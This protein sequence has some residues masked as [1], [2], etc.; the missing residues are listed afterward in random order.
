MLE[1]D[2]K[3]NLSTCRQVR[4]KYQK[5][6]I[7][8]NTYTQI[9][10]QCVF[11]VQ[12]RDSIISKQW[13]AELHKYITG[14]IQNYGHKVLAIN[15]MPD[16]VHVFFGM[17]PTQSLSDLMQDV[18][19]DSSKWINKNRFIKGHFSWQ[20]GYGGFSYSKSQVNDVISYINNQ[21]KHHKKKSFMEEYDDF[22]KLFDIDFDERFIFRPIEYIDE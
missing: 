18:K 11:T 7:M 16:H 14:I 5:I 20:E 9:H 13:K 17:R 2:K 19:G 21:E 6:I 10:I 4:Y 12:N 1:E 22:L 8:A 15:S 3:E